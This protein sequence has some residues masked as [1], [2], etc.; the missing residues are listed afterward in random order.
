MTR[1][2]SSVEAIFLAL[3]DLDPGERDVLLRER[4]GHD[5]T[6]RAEVEAMLATL[7]ATDEGFLDPARIPSL[8]MAAADGPL[9]PGTVLGDF[10][11]LHALGSGGMGVVYAA[12]QDH[13][14]RTSSWSSSPDRQSPNTS[15]RTGS[16]TGRASS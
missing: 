12:Q 13:P 3:A 1:P 8:D 6:L 4:C 15:M 11:V 14:R 5:P 10:L 2:V 16:T 9:Q 7:E